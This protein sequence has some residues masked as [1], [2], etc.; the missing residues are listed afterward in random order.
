MGYCGCWHWGQIVPSTKMPPLILL[1]PASLNH[2]QQ[3]NTQTNA[4]KYTQIYTIWKYPY[5]EIHEYSNDYYNAAISN[6]L[7]VINNN[8]Q[9]LFAVERHPLLLETEPSDA[10]GLEA[11]VS[12]VSACSGSKDGDLHDKELCVFHKNA[13]SRI[14]RI[15]WF[16]LIIDTF[17]K[18]PA[19]WIV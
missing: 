2:R 16:L 17:Q 4:H 11:L 15:L 8:K 7:D 10:P 18:Q 12:G 3:N 6:G 1:P 14:Q 5:P 9:R 13:E 19:G